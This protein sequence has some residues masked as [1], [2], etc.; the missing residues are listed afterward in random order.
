MLFG[1]AGM[2]KRHKDYFKLS[3][4]LIE[5]VMVLMASSIWDWF[6]ACNRWRKEERRASKRKLE[7]LLWRGYGMKGL[8][9]LEWSCSR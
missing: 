3:I 8:C 1:D 6:G 5:L 4:F 9:L 7:G 2:L